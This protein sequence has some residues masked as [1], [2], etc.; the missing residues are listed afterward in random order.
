[1]PIVKPELTVDEFNRLHE[2][3][4]RRRR[5]VRQQAAY[6]IVAALAAGLDDPD[7]AEWRRMQRYQRNGK[8]G[9]HACSDAAPAAI[10]GSRVESGAGREEDADGDVGLEA[11]QVG[12]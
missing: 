8:E 5:E 12:A 10:H 9:Q 1:V 6:L 11:P 7:D 3:A 2:L 4:V